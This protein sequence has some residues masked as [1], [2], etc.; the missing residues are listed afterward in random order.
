[1]TFKVGDKVRVKI[2]AYNVYKD[3][4]INGPYIGYIEEIGENIVFGAKYAKKGDWQVLVSKVSN[5]KFLPNEKR[6]FK[7]DDIEYM[8]EN[9]IK[10]LLGLK[11]DEN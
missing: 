3:V 8:N 7:V 4:K 2:G 6:Y 5:D 9:L 1:M 10:E 11:N